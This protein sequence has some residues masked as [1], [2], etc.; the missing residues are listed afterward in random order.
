[1]QTWSNYQLV[2][3]DLLEDGTATKLASPIKLFCSDF[4]T[5]LSDFQK[6]TE[7]LEISFVAC[8]CRENLPKIFREIRRKN[9]Y[10]TGPSG[11][12]DFLVCSL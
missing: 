3:A 1:M 6:K 5:D 4:P 7:I 9:I 12:N 11:P 2:E 8:W 10:S